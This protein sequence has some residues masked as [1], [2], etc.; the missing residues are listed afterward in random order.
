MDRGDINL[1]LVEKDMFV[2]AHSIK[3]HVEQ[4][5]KDAKKL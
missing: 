4:L 3:L 5:T 1:V 2:D